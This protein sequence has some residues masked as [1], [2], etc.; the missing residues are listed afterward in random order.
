MHTGLMCVVECDPL[1]R[2]SRL[3]TD[4]YERV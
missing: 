2:I 4:I 3:E 1:K